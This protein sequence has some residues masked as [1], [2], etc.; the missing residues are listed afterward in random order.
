MTMIA[1]TCWKCKCVYHLPSELH[2]AA[3][4]SESISFW[5]PYEH[6]AHFP[7]GETDEDKLRRELNSQRQQ[8]ARLEDEARAS[9]AA[10]LKAEKATKRLKKR[11]AAGV[12]PCCHRTVGQMAKHMA[13]KHPEFVHQNVARLHA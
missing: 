5:C 2:D 13:T 12:C 10:A 7:Q 6:S 9:R 4:R 8:N 11:V 1:T 3:R